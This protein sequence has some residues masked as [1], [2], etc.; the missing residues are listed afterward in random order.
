MLAEFFTLRD[1][2]CS[3]W[4]VW[5]SSSNNGVQHLPSVCPHSVSKCYTPSQ[6]TTHVACSLLFCK[7][8]SFQCTN[9]SFKGEL[10]R[11]T[12]FRRMTVLNERNRMV[13]VAPSF[14]IPLWRYDNVFL[15]VGGES[16]PSGTR[17]SFYRSCP[18]N[19][20]SFCYPTLLHEMHGDRTAL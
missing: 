15:C 17:I 18:S 9:R 14:S 20:V 12:P 7:H 2:L 11:Q 10:S 19:W 1:S 3:V 4:Q 16:S 6:L 8:F 5:Y 13:Q